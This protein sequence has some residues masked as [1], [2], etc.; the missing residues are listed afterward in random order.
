VFHTVLLFTAKAQTVGLHFLVFLHSLAVF[1]T[2]RKARLSV[3]CV[4]VTFIIQQLV[5]KV[6]QKFRIILK[7]FIFIFF[8]QSA[9]EKRS[10]KRQ[11]ALFAT[12]KRKAANSQGGG[13]P[14]ARTK[15]RGCFIRADPKH[16]KCIKEAALLSKN[17]SRAAF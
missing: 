4:K 12:D 6:K 9:A 11:K 3:S 15:K 5:S 8:F 14:P 2:P 17:D 16:T 10:A 1:R 7:F 13:L